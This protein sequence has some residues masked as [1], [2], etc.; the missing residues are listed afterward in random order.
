[1]LE[2]DV[3]GTIE[4]LAAADR[5]SSSFISRILRLTLLAPEI[6]EAILEG[7]KPVEMTLAALISPLPGHMA[8]AGARIYLGTP[9]MSLLLLKRCHLARLCQ[10]H[11]MDRLTSDHQPAILCR[12]RYRAVQH[13]L[14]LHLDVLG[15]LADGHPLRM[16]PARQII[17][18]FA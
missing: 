10:Q 17:H 13:L 9:P 12:E 15:D 4:E 5:L 2:T 18:A 7:R 11:P 1:M 8:G 3:Y 16:F 6:V 14:V